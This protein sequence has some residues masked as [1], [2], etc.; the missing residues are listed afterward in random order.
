MQEGLLLSFRD[1]TASLKDVL[2][3]CVCGGVFFNP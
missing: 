1:M 2:L 3:V